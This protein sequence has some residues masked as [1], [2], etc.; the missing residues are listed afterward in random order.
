MISARPR[1]GQH[2]LV[3]AFEV[4]VRSRLG[5][6]G[7]ADPVSLSQMS[8]RTAENTSPRKFFL[9]RGMGCWPWDHPPG[10]QCPALGPE[11]WIQPEACCQSSKGDFVFMAG[12]CVNLA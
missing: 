10:D 12:F 3:F 4:Q 5:E 11:C 7:C 1:R 6:A 8:S 2:F 9:S